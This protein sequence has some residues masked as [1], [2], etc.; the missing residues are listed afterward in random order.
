MTPVKAAH[1]QTLR[2]A[3][4]TIRNYYGLPVVRAGANI[5]AGK[6]AVKNWPYYIIELRNA[7]GPVIALINGFD[8][9]SSAFDVWQLTWLPLGTGRP[10][11]GCD[12]AAP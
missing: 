6:T 2:T 9:A 3:V 11:G 7:I 5:I 12:A 8:A 4:N 10:E 1:I